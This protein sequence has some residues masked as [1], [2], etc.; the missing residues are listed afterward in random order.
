MAEPPDDDEGPLVL[1]SAALDALKEFYVDRDARQ[2]QFEDL[3]AVAESGHD[4]ATASY[5]PLSMEA[6]AEDWNESQ[7]WYSDDTAV[8]LAEE[9]L[10]GA[11][12]ETTIAVVSAPSVFVQIKNLLAKEGKPE[13]ERP[14]IS[15][16][17]FD[18]RFEVFPEFVF[19]DF[20]APL[21]LPPALKG[22]A[23]RVICDPPF[24]SE[25]CQTKA[26]LTVRWLSKAW[27]TDDYRLIVCTGERMESLINKLYRPAV[28][29]SGGIKKVDE[30]SEEDFRGRSF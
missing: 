21:K 22:C 15:L 11:T 13:K 16:L 14:K 30:D 18:K 7:F 9:L 25:D 5:K 28:G 3:K 17:E 23:T 20:K 19:Y 10:A 8:A 24:L 27:N 29:G 1:S 26:A 12:V 6:F 4:E 2:K